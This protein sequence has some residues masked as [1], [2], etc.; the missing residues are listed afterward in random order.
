MSEGA[1]HQTHLIAA[2][3]GF[4]FF[5]GYAF[6]VFFIGLALF[7]AIWALSGH[8]RRSVTPAA[9][10][11]L[12]GAAAAIGLN[13][14]DIGQLDPITDSGVIERLSEVAVIV[15]LFAAGLRI[16]RRLGWR[17]WRS[18]VLLI[19]VVMPVT[20]AAVA[21]FANTLMGLSLGAALLLG[22]SLAPTDPVLARGVQVAGPGEGD[23]TE[24]H[25]A[26]TSEAGLNDGLAFPFV[27]LALFIAGEP[28]VGW[29]AEWFTADVLYAIGV[30]VSIGI[31]GGFSIGYA[32]DWLRSKGLLNPQYDGWVALAAVLLIYGLT[33]IFSAYGF[34]AAFA[35]GLA[36]RRYEWDHEAHHRVHTGSDLVENI[37]ELAMLVLLGSTITLVGLEQPGFWGWILVPVLIVLIRPLAVLGSFIGSSVPMRQRAFIGWF[38]IRGVGSFYYAAVGIG[39]GVLSLEEASTIYWTIIAC[40][41]VSILVHG[42]TSRP[43]VKSL[44]THGCE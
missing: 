24:S 5:D 32:S 29:F 10:Y 35:G 8:R 30:G 26:L 41:G 21:L 19:G 40:V 14:L 25:F 17:R 6:G 16:D 27:L 18:T 42:M 15:A 22:A 13:L 7:V 20:I 23:R 44:E 11:L 36:F 4:S 9:V 33:E 28:G 38:G 39:A 12:L 1:L 43:A 3:P 34:L 2:S 31:V 37:L